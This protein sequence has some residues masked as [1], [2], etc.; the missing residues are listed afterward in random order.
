MA[1]Q[2]RIAADAGKFTDPTLFGSAAT[3]TPSGGSATTINVLFSRP[4]ELQPIAPDAQFEGYNP[5]ALCKATDV[6][7]AKKGDTLVISG[8]TYYVIKAL[9]A[10]EGMRVLELSEDPQHG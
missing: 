9:P 7:S 4:G 8:T 10:S 5:S 2:D 1:L 6:A 3:Y